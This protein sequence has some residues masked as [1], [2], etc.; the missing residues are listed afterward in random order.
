LN[1]TRDPAGLDNESDAHPVAIGVISLGEPCDGLLT[2]AGAVSHVVRVQPVLRPLV[3]QLHHAAVRHLRTRAQ[4]QITHNPMIKGDMR[5]RISKR[6]SR[7]NPG[8]APRFPP[9]LRGLRRPYQRRS[10]RRP[11]VPRRARAGRRP[12]RR[13]ARGAILAGMRVE[14]RW[15][16]GLFSWQP[17][18]GPAVPWPRR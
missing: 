6:I 3:H 4:I 14:G 11:G 2:A 9:P 18:R 8:R 10:R 16:P 7:S 13:Q 1:Q 12:S 15:R 17:G 5:K